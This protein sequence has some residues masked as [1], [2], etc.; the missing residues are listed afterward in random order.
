MTLDQNQKQKKKKGGG[1]GGGGGAP[2]H[3]SILVYINLYFFYTSEPTRVFS[4]D[5][6]SVRN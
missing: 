6:Y 4:K 1:G 2:I 3:R 5:K